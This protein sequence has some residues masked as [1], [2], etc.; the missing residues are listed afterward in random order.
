MSLDR[1]IAGFSRKT[2]E[3]KLQWLENNF[4]SKEASEDYQRFWLEDRGLQQKFENFSENNLSNY[5][6]PLGIVPNLLV[7][8]KFYAVP[9]VTEESSVVAAA[10]AASRN[11][12]R[13]V[14]PTFLVEKD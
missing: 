7:N 10:A 3:E 13:Q 12:H 2:K 6:L 1:T 5:I 14:G 11:R 9:L 8:G 4:I